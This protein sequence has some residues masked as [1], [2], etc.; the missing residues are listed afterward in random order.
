[1]RVAQHTSG[2]NDALTLMLEQGLIG[3]IFYCIFLIRLLKF[4]YMLNKHNSKDSI[5]ANSI[6]IIVLCMGM[7]SNLVPIATYF[8][9]LTFAIGI[10]E[11]RNFNRARRLHVNTYTKAIR[12]LNP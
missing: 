2:H 3:V 6:C 11:G 5:I 4:S 1:M 9:F 7:F 10:L 8:T 12:W